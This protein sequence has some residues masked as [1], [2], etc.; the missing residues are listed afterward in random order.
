LA[1]LTQSS[2]RDWTQALKEQ[3]GRKGRDLFMPLRLALTGQAHGPEM[4]DL[5]PLIGYQK[6]VL[7]L[8][9]KKG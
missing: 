4:K 3:T 2:W 6:S 8:E 5:L 7:R 9:G 1:P